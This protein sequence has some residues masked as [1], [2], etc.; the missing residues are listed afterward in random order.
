MT[1][2]ECIQWVS[3]HPNPVIIYMISVPAIA[4]ILSMFFDKSGNQSPGKYFFSAIIYATA[5]PGVLAIVLSGYDILFRKTDIKSVN[6][7]VYFLP[8]I[9]MAVS[10]AII[11]RVVTM[12]A[13][14]GVRRL[15]GLLLII[16]VTS[17]LVFVLERMFI[18]VIFFGS[19]Y[20]FLGMFVILF[21]IIKIGWDK[22]FG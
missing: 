2:S 22:A 12:S 10:L 9:S 15:S 6:I 20:M 5:L 14:P 7:L 16:G 21:V 11:N 13:I 19:V 3:Q 18:G 17:I 1:I 4:F 8:I